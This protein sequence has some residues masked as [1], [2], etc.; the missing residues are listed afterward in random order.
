[1]PNT[2]THYIQRVGRTA[3]ARKK[4][5]SVSLVGETER[6]LLKQVLKMAKRSVEKRKIHESLFFSSYRSLCNS[7][8]YILKFCFNVFVTI[9]YNLN[10]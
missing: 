7:I 4:G 1:M 6:P 8:F 9:Y 2:L 10:D 5:V 3:R